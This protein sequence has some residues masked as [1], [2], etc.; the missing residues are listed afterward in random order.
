[1]SPIILLADDHIMLTNGLMGYLQGKLGYRQIY[2]V[3]SCNGILKE[4]KRTPYTHLVLDIALADGSA[5]EILETL[6][7]LYPKLRILLFSSKPAETYE[8]ALRKYKVEGYLSKNANEEQTLEQLRKFLENE[9]VRSKLA[10]EPN[11]FSKLTARELEIL[12]YLV[13]GMRLT[14]IAAVLN[15][16]PSA[17]GMAKANIFEKTGVKNMAGLIELS[18]LLNP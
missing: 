9:P 16:G 3:A 5:F 6:N 15:V 14:D 8:K 10:E 1:M 7:N 17:I 11:P 4:L 18:M 13:K 12:H 2:A